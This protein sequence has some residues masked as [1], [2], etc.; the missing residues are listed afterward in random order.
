MGQE[1]AINMIFDREIKGLG[2]R[3]PPVDKDDPL[4]AGVD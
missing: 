2:G 1:V 4:K 3:H